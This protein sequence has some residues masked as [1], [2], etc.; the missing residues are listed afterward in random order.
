MTTT[1]SETTVITDDQRARAKRAAIATS[2]GNALE[3]FDILVYASF[4]VV[5]SK[6]FFPS[7]DG[8]T[9]LLLVLGTF[10]LSYVI[11]PLGAM[12][13]GNYADTAGSKK[14]LT[15]TILLMMIGTGMMAFAPTAGTIGAWAG[16]IL[17][18]SRL[19][20]G[21]SAGGEFG[22]STA[23]LIEH[24]PDH[25]AFYASWQIAT[26]GAAMF[27]ASAF[28]FGLN[29]FLSKDSLESWGW[30]VPFFFGMLIGPVG[31]YI[32]MKM[33]E[34]PEFVEAEVMASPLR[35]TFTHHL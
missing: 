19:L 2:V 32:R 24:A 9:G 15:L 16:V 23:F 5:I 26:Q 14:A 35:T 10:G 28:G 3:L 6:L 29:T 18:A 25:K 27:L 7:A 12:V 11:R 22:T 17:L 8:V 31:L 4:A 13:L 34:T 21:F 20:Q 30:R 1:I 33:S